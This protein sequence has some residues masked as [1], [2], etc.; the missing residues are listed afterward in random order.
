MS[1][2]VV[3]ALLLVGTGSWLATS[4]RSLP[5]DG[6]DDAGP[7]PLDRTGL[8]LAGAS[9]L[10]VVVLLGTVVGVLVGAVA[11]A[12]AYWLHG[13]VRTAPDRQRSRRLQAQSPLALDL[14][15]S[16]LEAGL[17]LRVAVRTVAE[18][19]AEPT[20]S[21]LDLVHAQVQVGRGEADAWLVAAERPGNEVWRDPAR[22]LARNADSGSA[23][24]Q[25]LREHAR[26][27][28]TES[29]HQVEKR[30]KSVG[31]RS[32]IPMMCCYLPAFVMVGVVP[33]IGG[34]VTGLF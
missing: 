4:R 19:S 14:L 12:G 7:Q 5:P 16:A 3:L 34:L 29:A 1:L 32:V 23:V 13:R 6:D 21:V 22:D 30:A 18:V 20:R 9:G 27:Q 24:V 28:R 17:P 15:A 10:V 26:Q 8:L 31:V 33:I 25:V 2:D 11:G